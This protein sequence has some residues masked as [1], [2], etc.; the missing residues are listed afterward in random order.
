MAKNTAKQTE[1]VEEPKEQEMANANPASPDK[2]GKP[3]LVP[4]MIVGKRQTDKQGRT[5][6][7]TKLKSGIVRRDYVAKAK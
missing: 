2:S 4:D 7:E 5:Y 6:I 3:D 1:K